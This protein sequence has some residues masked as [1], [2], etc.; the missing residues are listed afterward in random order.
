[1]YLNCHSYFSFKYG[2]LSIE[3]LFREA[4]RCGI[5]KIALTDINNTSGYIELLRICEENREEYDLEVALGIE[6]RRENELLYITLAE[7][8]EGFREINGYLSHHNNT[9]KPLLSRAPVF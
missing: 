7:D 6:F 8:N 3:D 5:R 4:Q 1:M 9:D 2:T